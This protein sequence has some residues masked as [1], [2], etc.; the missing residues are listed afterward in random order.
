MRKK[1]GEEET[2]RN[3]KCKRTYSKEIWKAIV[4]EVR[5]NTPRWKSCESQVEKSFKARDVNS[6]S[7]PVPRTSQVK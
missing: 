7:L 6:T 1:R 3:S 2:Q 4:R 5:D